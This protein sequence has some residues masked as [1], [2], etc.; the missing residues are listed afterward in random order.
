MFVWL[1]LEAADDD[2]VRFSRRL[3]AGIADINPDLAELSELVAMHGGGLGTPLIEALGAQL[4]DLPETVI[5][6]DDLHQLSNA[7]LIAD[8]GRLVDLL[9][10][11][12]HL[13]LATRVDP[14][15]A[16]SHHRLRHRVTEI[17]QAELAFD[18]AEST[19]LLERITGRQ[20]GIRPGN[21]AGQPDRGLG[22]RTTAGGH[23][24]P[25]PAATLTSSS[26]SSVGMTG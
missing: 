14:P 17:R 11:Q 20:L 6:L 24:A 8:L 10:D 21:R 19:R 16:W 2:P 23:D 25:A 5:I 26:P 15:I 9:P 18:E 1:S 13:V 7:T 22:G 4:H 3:L 12:V